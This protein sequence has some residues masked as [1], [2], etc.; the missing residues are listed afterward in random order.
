MRKLAALPF[1]L[2]FLV[3]PLFG[4]TLYFQDSWG[5]P[6]VSVVEATDN[7]L[8]VNFS[9]TRVSFHSVLING[10]PMTA[11]SYPAASMGNDE[12]APCL[13]GMGRFF[14]IPQGASVQYEIL[15]SRVE[16][17]GGLD[18]A[19][20]M[21][22]PFDNEDSMPVYKKD[23]LIYG[24][25][26]FYPDTPVRVS[27]PTSLRGV[28]A[29]IIGITPFQYNPV[30]RELLVYSDI[31][32]KVDFKGGNGYIGE[33]RLRSR[34]F[35]PILKQHLL[36]ADRLPV[37][38]YGQMLDGA[39]ADGAEYVIIIPNDGG[40]KKWANVIKDYR[41]LQGVKTAVYS[42]AQV[43]NTANAIKNWIHTA[44]KTWTPAPVAVLLLGDAN[45]PKSIPIAYY[46]YTPSDNVYAD[47]FGND[48]LPDIAI[49]RITARNNTELER[50]VMKGINYENN[51]PTKPLF[52]DAPLMAAGWQS[53]RWFVICTEIVLGY[54]DTVMGKNTSREYSGYS[55]G[56][57]SYWSTN[58]NTYMLVD[59]FGPTGLGYIPTTPSH[60]TDWTGDAQ[61][62]TDCFNAGAFF[63]MHR[64]HGMVEGWWDPYYTIAE[65][66]WLHNGSDL[67]YVMSFNCSSGAFAGSSECFAEAMH[68]MNGGAV[69]VCA[70]SGT[71]YSF[72]NDTLVFGMIDS[73]FPD[74]DPGYKGSTGD[75]MLMPGFALMSG[76]YYLEASNWPYNTSSKPITYHLFHNHCDTFFTMNSEV[77]QPLSVTH[78]S[79]LPLGVA[80]FQ[81]TADQDA[82]IALTVEDAFEQTIIGTDVATGALQNVTITPQNEAR[83]MTVTVTKPNHYRY[84]GKVYIPGLGGFTPY[85][86]GLAG[87]GGY[88]PALSG[89]GEPI[90]GG[91]IT[92]D[93]QDA[94]GG[95][96][97]FL[98][99]GLG[100]ASIP[101]LGGQFLVY[102]LQLALP[103][104]CSGSAGV[105]GAGSFSI[106]TEVGATNVTLYM[107]VLLADPGAVKGV[108]MSNGLEFVLP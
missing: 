106:P 37:I 74:F 30:T 103:I 40:F 52:Y 105:P 95:T 55:G 4:E 3:C 39:R 7:S 85:G 79:T 102:P 63:A 17:M 69:G 96:N 66:S 28:D 22:I 36:N 27:D 41:T 97:G 60:L 8:V 100:Q 12:D 34:F 72:V 89:S 11:V 86:Q 16:R 67:P 57:P 31:R 48:D 81:I 47:V 93:L 68:R 98:Y 76:K 92:I 84:T 62:I 49:S 99:L 13:P 5:P 26:A 51:P 54:Y 18:I 20:T 38:D 23:P 14:A 43:G 71:S 59:Y 45:G 6:G 15:D 80:S 61:G 75:D 87:S 53:D 33:D 35:D 104:V 107:Q 10:E 19:P 108:S 50:M 56:A 44:V 77:P 73:M 91:D 1:L 82:F 65:L 94:L 2:V 64:D 32:V 78:A 46:S 88:V 42:L 21:R 24:T 58:S 70:A 9:M 29:S 101:L 25:N 90:F 83:I